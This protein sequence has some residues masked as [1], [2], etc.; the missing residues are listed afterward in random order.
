MDAMIET[1]SLLRLEE[2]Q[3]F[4]ALDRAQCVGVG[5]ELAASY[6]SAVPFP[7]A[8]L[9]SFLAEDLLTRVAAEFPPP[10]PGRFDDAQSRF[11]TGYQLDRIESPLINALINAL[12]S[13]AFLDFLVEMT[14]IKGLMGDP[15]QL[16]GGLHETRRG[17]HLSIH[18]DFNMHPRLKLKRRLNLILFL[19]R[20]WDPAFGGALELWARDMSACRASVLP[21]I[22]RAVIFNTDADSFHGHPDPLTCPKDRTRR[23]LAMYYYAADAEL[24]STQMSRT[25]D[26][27]V[28]PGSH[29]KPDVKTKARHL[30]RDL[31]PPMLWRMFKD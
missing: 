7:H 9:E 5:K 30:L 23:S 27:R 25:T 26:F 31:T 1:K 3:G 20:D 14:G 19:N 13:H 28:R 15:Y 16:G 18:A 29:D 24:E 17:G 12:N 2:R 8:V 21:E 11:K 4:L 22:G 6:Q 10:A